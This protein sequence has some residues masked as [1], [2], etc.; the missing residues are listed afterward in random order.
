MYLGKRFLML[1]VRDVK[2]ASDDA[3]D[4]IIPPKMALL[5]LFYRASVAVTLI[6]NHGLV[7]AGFNSDGLEPVRRFAAPDVVFVC[8][9]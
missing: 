5:R 3:L 2:E 1:A 6:C 9:R 7:R 8:S 4:S